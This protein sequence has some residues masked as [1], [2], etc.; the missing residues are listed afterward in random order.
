MV[1]SLE[2]RETTLVLLVVQCGYDD[3]NEDVAG[4]GLMTGMTMMMMMMLLM[5]IMILTLTTGATITV[6]LFLR[7]MIVS[8]GGNGTFPE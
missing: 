1:S 3:D 7:C 8:V 4:D 5:M 2:A 6:V